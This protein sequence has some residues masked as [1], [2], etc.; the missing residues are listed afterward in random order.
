MAES[1][2]LSLSLTLTLT[3]VQVSMAESLTELRE[4]TI[5]AVE[6]LWARPR[7]ASRFYWNG[8][9]LVLKMLTDMLWA[10]LPQPLD[11]LSVSY[12]HLTLPTTPYV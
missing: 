1:L 3:H 12:T 4:S 9:D 5:D 6:L 10:P 7:G 11:P 8:M 2:I